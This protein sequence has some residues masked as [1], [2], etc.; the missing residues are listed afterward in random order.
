[1][2]WGKLRNMISIE[3]ADCSRFTI[4]RATNGYLLHSEIDDKVKVTFYPDEEYN[5]MLEHIGRLA[6][7]G[8]KYK[9]LLSSDDVDKGHCRECGSKSLRIMAQ[10]EEC[11][12]LGELNRTAPIV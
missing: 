8:N 11:N 5:R 12:A 9:V 7:P 6:K 2:S 3:E 1:M 10:C 4:I